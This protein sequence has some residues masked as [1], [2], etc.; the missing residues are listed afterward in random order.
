MPVG[1]NRATQRSSTM[2]QERPEETVSFNEKME[3]LK[4][5]VNVKSKEWSVETKKQSEIDAKMRH[6]N[7]QLIDQIN[8]YIAKDNLNMEKAQKKEPRQAH[9]QE[10]SKEPPS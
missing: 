7:S 10:E 2:L 5:D 4:S 8:S 6:P 1:K 3:S 9:P